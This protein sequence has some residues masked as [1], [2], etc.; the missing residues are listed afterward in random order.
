MKYLLHIA[1]FLPILAVVT[2]SGHRSLCH[3]VRCPTPLCANPVTPPGQCCPSCENSGCNFAGCVQFLKGKGSTVQWKPTGCITCTCRNNETLCAVVG[4]PVVFPPPPDPCFGHPTIFK[5]WECCPVCNFD[6]PE[7][8][9]GVVPS[10]RR[11][12]TLSD[13]SSMCS[14][15]V[16]LHRCDKR[17]FLARNGKRFRCI[18]VFRERKVVLTGC[19][20]YTRVFYRD[21]VRCRARRDDQ[22]D[23]GCDL[24]VE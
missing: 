1:F 9:C 6:V 13:E 7:T 19:A 22:L 3:G 15:S 18:P 5:P 24:L 14:E 21:V 16:L 20:P 4:C 17:G 10:M 2:E 8:K 11:N 12:L 23:V